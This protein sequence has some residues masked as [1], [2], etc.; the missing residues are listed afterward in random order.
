MLFEASELFGS[1]FAVMILSI[2]E[3]GRARHW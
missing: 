1:G 3:A 2:L